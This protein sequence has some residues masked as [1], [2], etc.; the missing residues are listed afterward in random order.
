MSL[1]QRQ[2][3]NFS[4]NDEIVTPFAYGPK[5]ADIT[6]IGWGS[7]HGAI[8]EA[9]YILRKEGN[10][11]NM[12]HLSELWPFP[13]ETV[14]EV[15]KKS[16]RRYVIESNATGQLARLIRMETGIEATGKILRF[17]GRPFTPA[18]IVA[19]VKKEEY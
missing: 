7:T 2:E 8:R 10:S 4:L 6:L 14:T 9:M 12:L 16:K 11:I 1:Q 15:L 3:L 19:A 13:S 17:D 18:Y 5:R